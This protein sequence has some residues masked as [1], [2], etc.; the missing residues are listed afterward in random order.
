MFPEEVKFILAANA[1]KAQNSA[2]RSKGKQWKWKPEEQGCLLPPPRWNFKM[3]EVTDQEKNQVELQDGVQT[4]DTKEVA[5]SRGRPK[6]ARRGRLAITKDQA[7]QIKEATQ[8][9][10]KGSRKGRKRGGVASASEGEKVDEQ[11]V[12]EKEDVGKI[13]KRRRTKR[14]VIDQDVQPDSDEGKEKELAV[15]RTQGVEAMATARPPGR[16]RRRR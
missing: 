9:K 12:P 6:G 7:A 1:Q 8:G 11:K 10:F 15:V 5:K 13:V 14:K 2:A 16:K 4:S 3:T